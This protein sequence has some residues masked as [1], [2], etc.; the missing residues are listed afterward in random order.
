MALDGLTRS[1]AHGL[2]EEVL[3]KV[4]FPDWYALF[5]ALTSY[6]PEEGKLVLV[7]DEYP[8]LTDSQQGFSTIIQ[9]VWDESWRMRNV[10]LVLCG[11]LV[12]MMYKETLAASSPL[13]GRR[14]GQLRL[15]PLSF[16][17][18]C[19]FYPAEVSADELLQRWSLTGGVPRYL[20]LARDWPSFEAALENLVLR[21]HGVLYPEAGYLL[22]EEVSKPNLYMDLL[23][24]I[25][26]GANRISEIAARL[27]M[28][29]G[30]L[31]P[32]LDVLRELGMVRREVSVTELKPA[33]SKRGI[34]KIADPFLQLWYG[35]ISRFADL[36]E[37]GAVKRVRQLSAALLLKHQASCF[38]LACSEYVRD[39]AVEW[40]LMRVGRYW[41]RQNEIDVVGVD[42]AG[43][44]AFAG[45][46]KW[47]V[48]PIGPAVLI[49]LQEKI[50]RIWPNRKGTRTGL[51]S[52]SGFTPELIAEAK[53]S[54]THL[55]DPEML[56][57]A[58]DV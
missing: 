10:M 17:D 16:A 31:T 38:E 33:K 35:C 19:A 37:L 3:E 30:K 26:G 53:K 4:R 55:V 52:R 22:Q 24:V 41:D 49:A 25:G 15:D 23:K 51:F 12:S 28:A 14:S 7:L 57:K 43:E 20:E 50:A 2:E 42:L 36:I 56:V 46:C 47:S 9:K 1:M 40:D 13:Y 5:E 48:N 39:R 45:E 34:Y 21:P 54:G 8:Y 11:S 58:L 32:Y 6:I 18:S 27:E 29:A 44:V